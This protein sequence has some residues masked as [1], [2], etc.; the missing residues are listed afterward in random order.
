MNKIP[1][2][3]FFQAYFDCRKSKRNS[4]NA[5]EFE[6]DF[7]E[8]VIK[9]YEDVNKDNYKVG[10]LNVFIVNKPVKREVFAAKFRDRIVHHLVVN[11]LNHLFEREFIYDS[12]SCRKNK[13]TLFGIERIKRF[14]R[15]CSNNYKDDC[16]ILKADIKGYFMSINKDILVEKLVDFIERNCK[17]PDKDKVIWLCE[18]IINNNSTKNC[19]MKSPRYKWRGLPKSKS[20]FYSKPRCGLPIGNYTNQIFANF[21]LNFF[22]HFMKNVL[23]IKY[24]GRYVD[25]F[26]LILKDKHSVGLVLS[27]MR[28]FLGKELELNT[29]PRKIYFQHYSKGVAFLGA[30]IKPWRVYSSR[31]VKNNFWEKVNRVNKILKKGILNEKDKVYIRSS[32]NSYLGILNHFQT[33]RLREKFLNQLDSS[34]WNVFEKGDDL[35]KVFRKR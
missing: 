14:I 1:L 17:E 33:Y 23:K 18:E 5:L 2:E 12:Y 7:E 26:I 3:D 10:P 20:L 27:K 32:I 6:L 9:L 15:S 24:Y 4:L 25:D 11:K 16:W 28:D 21:Y 13:G 35:E 34:F 22:D 29:H 8:R 31:R 30:Y 19:F